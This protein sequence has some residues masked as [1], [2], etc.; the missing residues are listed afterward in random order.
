MNKLPR[1]GISGGR[2]ERRGPLEP[3]G[4]CSLG[5]LCFWVWPQGR[6]WQG[7][8]TGSHGTED[9]KV[10]GH[11][12]GLSHPCRHSGVLG[13]PWGGPGLW[14]LCPTDPGTLFP[15]ASRLWTLGL[16]DKRTPDG[17]WKC[18]SCHCPV[19]PQVTQHGNRHRLGHHS[20]SPAT[21]RQDP[22]PGPASAP[23]G[24]PWSG[25]PCPRG[26]PR[27]RDWSWRGRVGQC[28]HWVPRE[29]Q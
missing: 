29:W 1:A 13:A 15:E 20:P 23:R 4:P 18:R 9:V 6:A 25:I 10:A 26:L 7:T 2:D 11:W 3:L 22:F 14:P 19:T 12:W 17:F 24:L 16:L 8:G 27:A 21:A 5:G 28:G